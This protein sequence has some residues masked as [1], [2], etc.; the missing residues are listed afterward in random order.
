MSAFFK[1]M[2]S[3]FSIWI[4]ASRHFKYGK[5]TRKF[6]I[7]VDFYLIWIDASSQVEYGY[8]RDIFKIKT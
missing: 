4:T 8:L 6:K 5:K 2:L 1:I 7:F 3:Y